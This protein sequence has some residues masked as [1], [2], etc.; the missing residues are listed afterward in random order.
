MGTLAATLS[1]LLYG[2]LVA[3]NRL[4]AAL[5]PSRKHLHH[6]RFAQLHELASLHA[7]NAPGDPET[8]LLLGVGELGRVLRVRP[9][10]ARRELGNLLVVAPTRGGKGLLATSQL[11]T[12]QGS[13]VVNDIKGELFAQTAGY[14]STLGPVFVIDPI[15]V[16]HR[17]DPLLG[18]KTEDEL[19]SSATHLLFKADEGEGAIFTQR[20]TV[21]LTQLFLAAREEGA[22]PLPYVR[23][24]IRTGLT[25]SAARLE[26]ISP[27]LAT[28]FLDVEFCGGEFQRS[29]PALGLGDA[30]C[31]D[32]AAFDRDRGLL[33]RR[34]RFQRPGAHV[35][36]KPTT[37]YL[38]WPERDLLALSP[39]VRLLWGSLIDELITTYDSR[40]GQGV[41]PGAPSDR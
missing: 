15:G 32:A 33:A 14:R 40:P 20:A 39:L 36:D 35:R 37:V 28:Q 17:Y 38:R 25:A 11:L 4:S 1:Q 6:A 30:V 29:L 9:T 18:K 12:W 24:I 23:Q 10:R 41:P 19:L 31:P 21:M 13:V 8:S 27:E 26:A 16:G 34:C 22:S 5:S 3:L 7:G 2:L